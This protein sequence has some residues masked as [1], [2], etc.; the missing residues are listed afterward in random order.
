MTRRDLTRNPGRCLYMGDDGAF[1]CPTRKT[2][3]RTRKAAL[4]A[5]SNGRANS[6]QPI[7]IYRCDQCRRWHLTRSARDKTRRTGLRPDD[8]KP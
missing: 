7:F 1:L 3:Y 4:T 6:G 8:H 2:P 5:A